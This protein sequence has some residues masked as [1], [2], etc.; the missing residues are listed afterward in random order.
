LQRKAQPELQ[1]LLDGL[2]LQKPWRGMLE[3]LAGL[4]GEAGVLQ[5]ARKL[6]SSE[7]GIVAHLD[8]LEMVAAQISAE[9][10]E[11]EL[12]FDLAELRGYHYKNGIVFAAFTPGHGRELARGGRYDNIGGVFGRARPATGF[13]MDLKRVIT[14]APDG[15]NE[16][17]AQAIFVRSEL[18]TAAADQV[19]ILRQAGE[20]V[21]H[22]LSGIDVKLASTG[23]DRELIRQGS[24][25]S[26]TPLNG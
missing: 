21:V 10:P 24:N 4:H 6:F 7:P 20:R 22:G 17:A 5:Q 8:Y 18:R 26:I 11:I 12:N 2:Q 1:V 23:C 3:A 19:R 25:W 15:W 14:L 9:V 16:R 13:S